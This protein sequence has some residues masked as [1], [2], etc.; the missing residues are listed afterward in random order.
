VT[1]A[2]LS[3]AAVWLGWL[4][5]GASVGLKPASLLLPIA[6]SVMCL[7]VLSAGRTLPRWLQG[8]LTVAVGALFLLIFLPALLTYPQIF[9][10]ARP[11]LFAFAL[12]S[13]AQPAAVVASVA[14]LRRP[15]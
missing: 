11:N 3:I 9:G 4:T 14:D 8:L 7:Q 5:T 10:A 12:L 2:G 13:L 1:L 15:R 6:V